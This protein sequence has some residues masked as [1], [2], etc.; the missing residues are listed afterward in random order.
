MS[1]NI[2]IWIL[3]IHQK[4]TKEWEELTT[5]NRTMKAYIMRENDTY[6]KLCLT[7]KNHTASSLQMSLSF[8]VPK[9]NTAQADVS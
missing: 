7:A 8:V 5:S 3:T 4:M 6:T 2:V 9:P 1:L